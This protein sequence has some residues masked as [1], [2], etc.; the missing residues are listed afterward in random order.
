M[1]S[2]A[3]LA[4][5][6]A[7]A[8]LCHSDRAA[9]CA[10]CATGDPTLTAFG[11]DLPHAGRLRIA[12]D[13][14]TRE[15]HIGEAGVDRVD[16]A[17]L[18]TELGVAYAPTDDVFLQLALPLLWRD[19]AYADDASSTM[20]ASGDLG[21]RMKVALGAGL[22]LAAGLSLPTAPLVSIDGKR[23]PIEAQPG[24]GSF[25]PALGIGWSL[26]DRDVR[27]WAFGASAWG[28][29]PTGDANP[30]LRLVLQGQREL[31]R[32]G[33]RAFALRVVLEGRVDG[34]AFEGG[35]AVRHSGG[36]IGFAGIDL[37]LAP[38]V[39][40]QIELGLRVPVI[41]ALRGA[42]DEGMIITA[43]IAWDAF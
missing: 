18:R 35:A 10:A 42:H 33:A 32:D 20:L 27:P 25:D 37:T 28:V 21:F 19:V 36:F 13:V 9:A 39:D 26:S 40:W 15:D 7:L 38:V 14:R 11:N 8:S 34:R 22:S 3:A 29:W 4:A 1:R 2:L 6:V 24:T 12:V 17:E 41:N 16:V 5:L 43:S 23:L 30:Q 31:W